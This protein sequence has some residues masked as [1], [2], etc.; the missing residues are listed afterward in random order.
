[1]IA[2]RWLLT[3]WAVL[4]P[5]LAMA[6]DDPKGDDVPPADTISSNPL[7]SHH[8]KKDVF[9]R[10]GDFFTKYFRDFNETDTNYI[11]AQHYNYAL[12]LQNTS[13][14]RMDRPFLSH[15]SQPIAWDRFSAGDGSSWGTHST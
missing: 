2:A 4:M 11:E 10:I 13:V 12:M 8:S 6:H 5:L 3:I 1:M 9:H 7:S 14:A 15:R